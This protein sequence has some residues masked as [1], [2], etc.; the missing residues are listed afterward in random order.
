MTDC[1][2]A[3]IRDLLPDLATARLSA[4]DSA[5]VRAHLHGCAACAA[6]YAVICTVRALRPG[7][8]RVN[9]AAIVAAL[10]RPAVLAGVESDSSPS[11]SGNVV[12]LDER[13]LAAH[14]KGR[15]TPTVDAARGVWHARNVWKIAAAVGFMMVGGWSVVMLQ[16]NGLHVLV[17]GASDSARLADAAERAA[18]NDTGAMPPLAV[19]TESTTVRGDAGAAVSFGDVGGYTDD[20]LQRVL[21]RLEQWDGA[22]STESM[23]TAPILPIPAGGSPDDN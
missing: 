8:P 7:A 15:P 21:D 1:D 22:T 14:A 3:Q 18:A 23:T 10:P 4:E 9:V 5:R 13:R 19:A 11:V 20:E 12:S 2:N 16:P 17:S 6:E